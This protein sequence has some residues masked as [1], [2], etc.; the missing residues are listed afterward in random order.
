MG[1]FGLLRVGW[2]VL[3]IAVVYVGFGVVGGFDV[4]FALW[5]WRCR[6]C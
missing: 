5:V 3:D 2:V 6:S 4:V 1:G